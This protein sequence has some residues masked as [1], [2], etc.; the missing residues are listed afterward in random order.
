MDH[1][2]AS[3]QTTTLVISADFVAPESA[4]IR[5]Q[6]LIE[7]TV[8]RPSQSSSI[9]RFVFA[10]VVAASSCDGQ[11]YRDEDDHDGDFS[12]KNARPLV[13]VGAAAASETWQTHQSKGQQKYKCLPIQAEIESPGSRNHPRSAL[14]PHGCTRRSETNKP[15]RERSR[16]FMKRLQVDFQ[17]LCFVAT[18]YT[19]NILHSKNVVYSIESKLTWY[20]YCVIYSSR[21]HT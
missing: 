8:T 14:I 3:C 1:S 6:C 10:V 20:K 2:A 21:I 11:Q 18:F 16:F 12:T 15:R 5:S 19:I 17:W 7:P 9:A 13:V 4:P